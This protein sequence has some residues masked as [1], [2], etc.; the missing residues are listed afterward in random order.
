MTVRACNRS[1][2]RLGEL[3]VLWDA[4]YVGLQYLLPSLAGGGEARYELNCAGRGA[5]SVRVLERGPHTSF[6]E[7]QQTVAGLAPGPRFTLRVYHDARSAEVIAFQG[8]RYFKVH[9]DYPNSRMYQPDEK[10]QVNKLFHEWLQCQLS[11][12]CIG[13]TAERGATLDR[14]G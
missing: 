3:Q 6:I 14:P 4:N 5:V 11:A 8:H 1:R 12:L 10:Y 13:R 7:I 9:Y 2:A